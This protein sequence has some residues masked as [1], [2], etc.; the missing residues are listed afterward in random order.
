MRKFLHDCVMGAVHEREG[1]HR[2]RERIA[3]GTRAREIVTVNL[4]GGR[5]AGAGAG[6][7]DHDGRAVGLDERHS[8]RLHDSDAVVAVARQD[9][10]ERVDLAHGR[11]LAVGCDLQHLFQAI[12]STATHGHRGNHRH[13]AGSCERAPCAQPGKRPREAFQ[14]GSPP[15]RDGPATRSAGRTHAR[16]ATCGATM[17][18]PSPAQHA[19]AA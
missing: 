15:Q 17:A 10:R 19:A 9:R 5:R 6:W 16:T 1:A 3:S 18:Q 11:S 14:A 7:S 13:T 4:T 8:V 2:E 12:L